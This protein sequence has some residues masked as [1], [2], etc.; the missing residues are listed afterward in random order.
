M[1]QEP[2][3]DEWL[4]EHIAEMQWRFAKTYAKTSPHEYLLLVGNG[5]DVV[6]ELQRRIKEQGY[7]A[8][9]L[10]QGHIH[11]KQFYSYYDFDGYKYWAYDMLVNREPKEVIAEWAEKRSKELGLV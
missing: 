7:Q 9:F 8:E 2:R 6:K 11:T 4:R 5:H 1:P 10:A 3:S